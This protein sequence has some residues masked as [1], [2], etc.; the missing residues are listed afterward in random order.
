MLRTLAAAA[1]CAVA[2]LAAAPASAAPPSVEMTWMSIANWYFRIGDTRIVMDG[3]ITRVTRVPG[4]LF[5]AWEAPGRAHR[6]QRPDARG[7]RQAG[8]AATSGEERASAAEAP[9]TRRPQLRSLSFQNFA[10]P[11]ASPASRPFFVIV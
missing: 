8:A 3:C 10:V 1:T 2:T 4:S 5:V 6:R 9:R 11:T 7:G